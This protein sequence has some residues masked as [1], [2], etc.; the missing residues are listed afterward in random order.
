MKLLFGASTFMSII[1]VA[2]LSTL[3]FADQDTDFYY[4]GFVNPNT[5]RP[6]YY[7]DS[8]NVIQDLDL[9]SSLYIK[10]HGCV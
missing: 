8:N 9:F 5:E 2:T 4:P 3:T 7:K 10:Y 6:L 1:A